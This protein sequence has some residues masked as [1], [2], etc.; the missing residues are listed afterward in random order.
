MLCT[1]TNTIDGKVVISYRGLVASEVIFGANI[2][3]DILAGAADVVGGRSTSYEREF[4]R[5]RKSAV[6]ILIEKA[7][8]LQAD[9][10]V[11]MR[12]NYQVLGEKNGMMMV[13]AFGTAVQLIKSDDEKLKDEKR[14]LNE[15]A[16]FFVMIGAA[17]RGPFS[18][19]Q[20][21]ELSASGRLDDST[22]IWADG[23]EEQRPLADI[24]REK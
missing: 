22:M 5:A 24:L 6:K 14:A 4:E 20:L 10:I 2:L 21:R 15:E 18:L 17:K 11:G 13:A 19:D 23:R 9:A 16:V 7:E 8:A 3:R 1:T 12:F